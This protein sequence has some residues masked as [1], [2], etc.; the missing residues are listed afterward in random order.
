MKIAVASGK[1]GTGKTTLSVALARIFPG[2]VQLLDCDVEEPNV[3]LF[4]DPQITEK[5]DV[6]V[7]VPAVDSTLC[8]GCGACVR[9]CRF[10]AIALAGDLPMMFSDLCHSCGG[11]I[12]A[13]PHQALSEKAFSVGQLA[14]GQSGSVQVIEG[15]LRIGCAMGPPVIRAVKRRSTVEYPVLCDCP[16]G[17]ACSMITA[18]HDADF[19]LLVTEPTPFGLHDLKLA[20]ETVRLLNLPFGVV[21]N[22]SGQ[23]D[24]RVEKWC[25]RE[26]IEILLQ[27]PECRAVAEAISEG[28]TILDAIPSLRL[29]LEELLGGL[30]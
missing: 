25:E 4:L 7:G 13:C 10:N 6:T 22:R 15:R 9:A 2:T 29:Q 1:G 5:H 11:C 28:R 23:G 17:T 8:V 14:V 3:S 18:V 20:V 19:V 30:L 16:P 12:L 21:I 27:I 24:D 26:K